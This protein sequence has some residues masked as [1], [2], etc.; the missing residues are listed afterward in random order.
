MR[1]TGAQIRA[2]R[3]FLKWTVADLA[4]TAGV[5]ISTVQEIEKIDGDPRIESGLKWRSAAREE[6]I[7]KINRALNEAGITFLPGNAQGIGL[8]GILQ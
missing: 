4:K 5:G 8:R 2:A 1:I 7:E 3:A 6:A